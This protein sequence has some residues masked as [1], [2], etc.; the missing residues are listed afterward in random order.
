[1]GYINFALNDPFEDLS[2]R[3]KWD[4]RY[5][6]G[7][8]KVSALSRSTE[9]V[10]HRDGANP[11]ASSKSPG[12]TA[13]MAITL[14]RPR[15]FDTAFED[16]AKTVQGFYPESTPVS[17]AGFRKDIVIELYNEADQKVMAFNVYRCWPSRYEALSALDANATAIVVEQLTL[18]H[19][20]WGR[21]VSVIAP[22]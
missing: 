18:E 19:E 6:S 17:R 22:A 3:V 14:E 7:V 4:G 9:V 15:T 12:R 21:D 8:S 10:E 1:M 20:G 2:F 13:Y 11:A 5:I 16:W